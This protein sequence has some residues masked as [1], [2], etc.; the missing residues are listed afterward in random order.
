MRRVYTLRLETGHAEERRIKYSMSFKSGL[1]RTSCGSASCRRLRP[2]RRSSSM[3]GRVRLSLP[4]RIFRQNRAGVLAPGTRNAMP[5][6]AIGS[7]PH[8]C[9]LMVYRA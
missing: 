3:D 6:T 5:T 9:V 7:A 4:A 2:A 1:E 8:I